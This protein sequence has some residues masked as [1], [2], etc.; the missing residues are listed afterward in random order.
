[1][2]VITSEIS[3]YVYQESRLAF[4]I[5]SVNSFLVTECFEDWTQVREISSFLSSVSVSGP[6]HPIPSRPEA[7][8]RSGRFGA[9]GGRR[10]SAVARVA[11]CSSSLATPMTRLL[12]ILACFENLV[13]FAGAG[14]GPF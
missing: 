6:F 3:S 14:V 12:Q 8:T 5:L 7:G 2:Y 11:T 4:W 9:A 10:Q 13:Q 1:M